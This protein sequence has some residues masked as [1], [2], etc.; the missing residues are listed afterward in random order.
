M[1]DRKWRHIYDD[2]GYVS[3]ITE[4]WVRFPVCEIGPGH[5]AYHIEGIEE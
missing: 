4:A 3:V 1:H 2:V 5:V